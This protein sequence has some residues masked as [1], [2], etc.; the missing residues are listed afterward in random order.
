VIEEFT[1]W[2]NPLN[3]IGVPLGSSDS[4]LVITRG[5]FGNT[6]QVTS[7]R[8]GD[9]QWLSQ[10]L[11][12]QDRFQIRGVIVCYDLSNARSF[13]SQIRL[14]EESIPPTATVIRDDGTDLLSTDPECVTSS[15]ASHIPNGAITLSLRLNYGSAGDRIDIGALGVVLGQ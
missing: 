13:I 12:L 6:L 15:V 9:L 10:P 8:A 2:I 3:M 5:G 7:T 4:A 11:H 1:L 14:A